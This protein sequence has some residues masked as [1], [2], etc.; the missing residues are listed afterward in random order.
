LVALLLDRPE[1]GVFF[2]AGNQT[3]ELCDIRAESIDTAVKT[4]GIVA[5]DVGEHWH[6]IKHLTAEQRKE[7]RNPDVIGN[8]P[9]R[10]HPD[11]IGMMFSLERR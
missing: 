11:K 10:Y 5:D 6:S 4:D 2:P 8:R 7:A 3:V 1:N 9:R